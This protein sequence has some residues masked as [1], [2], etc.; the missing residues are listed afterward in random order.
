MM[1]TTIHTLMTRL[2]QTWWLW[3]RWLI[4]VILVLIV[5][6]V[7]VMTAL[8]IMTMIY[9]DDDVHCDDTCIANVVLA[10]FFNLFQDGNVCTPESSPFYWALLMV[11]SMTS[12]QQESLDT[13]LQEIQLNKSILILLPHPPGFLESHFLVK[14]YP[15]PPPS[16]AS[17]QCTAK[18]LQANQSLRFHQDQ[19]LEHVEIYTAAMYWCIN[20]IRMFPKIGGKPPKWMVYLEN[21]IKM[22]DL[23]GK[24]PLFLVQHPYRSSVNRPCGSLWILPSS[25]LTWLAGKSPCS[26]GNTSSK[27]SFSI[28]MLVYQRVCI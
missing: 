26:I 5:M 23:G 17:S 12:H 7:M 24:Q 15:P 27:G 3:W 10:S 21:P 22:D 8:T 2:R 16:E 6:I 28:A 20:N 4:V 13:S 25:K 14:N 18:Y 9:D 1:I 19:R 11:A